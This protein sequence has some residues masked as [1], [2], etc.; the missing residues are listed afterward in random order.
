MKLRKI[1]RIAVLEDNAF[2]NRIFSEKLRFYIETISREKAF[3]FVIESYIHVEDFLSNL[4]LDT[5][6]AFIDYYLENN[7]TGLEMINKIKSKCPECKIIILSQ[8]YSLKNSIV[9]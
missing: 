7:V 3:D 2:Y 5:D 4:K 6:I 9:S 1:I 8:F